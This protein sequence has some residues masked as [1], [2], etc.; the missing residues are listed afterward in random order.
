MNLQDS[1]AVIL[2]L[3]YAHQRVATTAPSP[4][5][6]D[7][8]E[9]LNDGIDIMLASIAN[10]A[11]QIQVDADHLFAS[12]VTGDSFVSDRINEIFADGT[13]EQPEKPNYPTGGTEADACT[14]EA[15]VDAADKEVK[16]MDDL[17]ALI[18]GRKAP[19]GSRIHLIRVA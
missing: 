1:K 3:A 8:F 18:S 2:A 16:T 4:Q 11:T 10:N 9:M 17:L 5:N 13:T 7:L 19:V 15:C 6:A 12:R 14:C